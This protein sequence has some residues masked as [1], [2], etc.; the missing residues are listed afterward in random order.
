MATVN[1]LREINAIMELAAEQELSANEQ[2]VYHALMHVFN[3]RACGN[4]WPDGYIKISNKALM[5]YLPI[6]EDA[7]S[8][9]RNQLVQHGLLLYEKGSRNSSAPLYQLIY[10]TQLLARAG[11]QQPA[12][13]D[14]DDADVYP[15]TA[16]KPAGKT[17][18]NSADIYY[19]TFTQ[20]LNKTL[21]VAKSSSSIAREDDDELFQVVQE[22]F[23]HEFGRCATPAEQ[24]AIVK[25]ARMHGMP[26]EVVRLAIKTASSYGARNVAQYVRMILADWD[27]HFV[28]DALDAQ[29][30]MYEHELQKPN[31]G[32]EWLLDPEEERQNG[33]KRRRA[34][35]EAQHNDGSA[36][37]DLQDD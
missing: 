10:P 11:Y 23:R 34:K 29:D 17:A 14:V 3:K 24:I 4:Q 30:Y 1:Y 15:H 5:Y 26:A 9:A 33:D 6:S 2:L 36:G 27:N 28:T 13:D 12:V 31:N 22:G 16:G 35:W 20:N 25:D 8:R 32:M 7:M 18:G 37:E 19:N 21:P